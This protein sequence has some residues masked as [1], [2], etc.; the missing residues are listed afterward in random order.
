MRGQED[1]LSLCNHKADCLHSHPS[2]MLVPTDR[3]LS[4]HSG[5]AL[6]LSTTTE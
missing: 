3:R 4:Y 6:T 2:S 1:R 5:L